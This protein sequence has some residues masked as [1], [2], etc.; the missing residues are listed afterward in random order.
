M[1]GLEGILS[2]VS[3]RHQRSR[4]YPDN[5][6]RTTRSYLMASL[7]FIILGTV[8]PVLFLLTELKIFFTLTI[9]CWAIAIILFIRGLWRVLHYYR[10]LRRQ[11]ASGIPSD[12]ERNLLFTNYIRELVFLSPD[13]YP[14]SQIPLQNETR[15]IELLERNP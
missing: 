10:F 13:G 14:S 4:E 12:R 7:L 2:S 5:G 9:V 3:P 6:A 11:E 8:T 1:Y 15:N